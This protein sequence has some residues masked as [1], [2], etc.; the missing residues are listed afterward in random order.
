MRYCLS[1]ILASASWEV[2][3]VAYSADESPLGHMVFFELKN[4]SAANQRKLVQACR[5]HLS[6]HE[7]TV[8]FS[9]G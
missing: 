3:R 8:H 9:V 6:G 2:P 5:K 7:G 1:F 4:D